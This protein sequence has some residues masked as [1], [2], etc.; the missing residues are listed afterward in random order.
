[1]RFSDREMRIHDSVAKD[2]QKMSSLTNRVI[3]RVRPLVLLQWRPHARGPGGRG[4]EIRPRVNA[5]AAARRG[6][7]AEDARGGGEMTY[8]AIGRKFEVSSG[9]VRNRLKPPKS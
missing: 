5:Q 1:M 4:I 9:T 2:A 6:R 7:D 8:S 3:H